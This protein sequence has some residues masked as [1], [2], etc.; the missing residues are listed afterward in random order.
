MTVYSKVNETLCTLR[1]IN[2]TLKIY[3]AQSNHQEIKNEF[4]AAILSINDV[5][6]DLEQRIEKLEYEEPQYKGL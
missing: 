1:G 2:G 4:D 5:I 3:S 6:S